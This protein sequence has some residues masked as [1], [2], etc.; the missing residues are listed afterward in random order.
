MDH[1]RLISLMYR[2][3]NLLRAEEEIIVADASIEP[4]QSHILG[5]LSMCNRY[6]NTSGG[7]ADFLCE[8]MAEVTPSIHG[9]VDAGYVAEHHSGAQD[10][11]AHYTLTDRGREFVEKQYPPHNVVGAILELVPMEREMLEKLMTNVMRSL[12]RRNDGVVFGVCKSCKHFRLNGL[13][14]THQC[15]LTREALSTE[16]SNKVCREH[17]TTIESTRA[18]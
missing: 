11:P 12:Q 5:Y 18:P 13:G 8:S 2:I 4:V 10:D 3:G 7:V 16:D 14:D 17:E 6:S 1:S 15:G 9:L